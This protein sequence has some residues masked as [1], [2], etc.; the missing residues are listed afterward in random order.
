M[1]ENKG[2]SSGMIWGATAL[3]ALGI[4]GVCIFIATSSKDPVSDEMPPELSRQIPV[5]KIEKPAQKIIE[6][7][8]EDIIEEPP[9]L[10]EIPL[11]DEQKETKPQIEI[12]KDVERK[13]N[14]AKEGTDE[15]GPPSLQLD[16][17]AGTLKVELPFLKLRKKIPLDN[18]CFR[19]NA[20]PAINWQDAPTGTKS[21]VVFLERRGTDPLLGWVLFNIPGSASGLPQRISASPELANGTK[22]ALSD[23][24]NIGYI[25]PCESKGKVKYAF[26]VFALNKE[27]DLKHS[28][29]KHELIKAMNGH[30]IDA[31]E[32]SFIHYYRF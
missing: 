29:H 18:T 12:P 32:K 30:I 11:P 4:L 10:L 2:L 6:E 25:G 15:S 28:V 17:L 7:P 22:H 9:G 5:Q 14:K 19:S 8:P 23:H 20:S 27:L 3:I 31:A 16:N 1:S 24:K 21:Y 26:R 13:L